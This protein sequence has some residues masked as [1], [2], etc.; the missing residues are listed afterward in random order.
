MEQ[1]YIVMYLDSLILGKHLAS[2]VL[3]EIIGCLSP[4]GTHIKRITGKM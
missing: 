1:F 2:Y 3:D 4:I